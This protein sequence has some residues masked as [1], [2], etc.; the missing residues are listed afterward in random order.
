MTSP[1]GSGDLGDQIN[2]LRREFAELT[3]RSPSNP[4]CRVK[5]DASVAMASSDTFAGTN[6]TA[7]EDPYGWHSDTSPAYIAVGL[8][9]FYQ[10]NFHANLTGLAVGAIGA[11]KVSLNAAAVVASIATDVKG[12]PNASEGIVLNAFRARVPLAAGDK[13]YWSTYCSTTGGTLQATSFGVPTEIT[14]QFVSSR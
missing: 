1:P 10:V 11:S 8:D 14:V 4:A 9:G 2:S 12:Q 6:W 3:R 7:T 13:L 5:L